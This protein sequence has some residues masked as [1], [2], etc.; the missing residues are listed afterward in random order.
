M[1]YSVAKSLG[2]CVVC[3][4]SYTHAA[5][6]GPAFSGSVTAS[7]L[8][9]DMFST[10]DDDAWNSFSGLSVEGYVAA[11]FANGIV[12]SADVSWLY[13]DL[14]PYGD[15]R[16]EYRNQGPREFEVLGLH[17]G[18]NF[19]SF[20]AGGFAAIGFQQTD[21]DYDIMR[22]GFIG[23]LEGKKSFG[24]LTVFGQLAYMD[25]QYEAWDGFEP[26][27]GFTGM[28]SR[29]GVSYDF[30]DRLSAMFDFEYGY[31]PNWFE[32]DG[33][34]GELMVGQIQLAYALNERFDIIAGYEYGQFRANTEDDGYESNITLGIRMSFG[35]A[36]GF[37]VLSTPVQGF[38][39]AG[40]AKTN[41]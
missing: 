38:A 41:D 4:L 34:W 32:D 23:G 28:M 37:N 21:L 2:A 40:W 16:N 33:D 7:Y 25:W 11:E 24:K 15:P 3:A 5:Q 12:V 18:K 19:G 36:S 27:N 22:E 20:Y 9:S 30:S 8:A 17:V 10:D 13:R 29:F 39:A 31:S 26:D 6:A 1:K 14:S 35:G